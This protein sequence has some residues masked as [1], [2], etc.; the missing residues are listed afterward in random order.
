MEIKCGSDRYI[1]RRRNRNLFLHI[2]R[3]LKN[4]T[5]QHFPN[6]LNL[7]E[8]IY[9]KTQSRHKKINSCIIKT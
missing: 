9:E 4:V 3:F 7:K 2:G 1:D 5:F 8:K 6:F